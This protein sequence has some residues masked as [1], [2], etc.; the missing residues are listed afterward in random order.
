MQALRDR[1]R[2]GGYA[3]PAGGLFEIIATGSVDLIQKIDEAF[4]LLG[5]LNQH[6][7]RPVAEQNAGAAVRVIDDP[8]HRV[9]ADH[10]HFLVRCRPSRSAPPWS[11]H[12]RS[13]STPR[14]DR[15][16][17][18]PF[19]PRRSCTRHA[20]DGNI[21]SGVTVHTIIASTSEASMPRLRQR[22][23]RGLHG[24]VGSGHV[25]RRDVPLR[26]ADPLDN[27]FVGRFDHLFEVGVRQHAGR[28]VNAERRNFCS[29]Q[30]SS[31]SSVR[32]PAASCEHRLTFRTP[33]RLLSSRSAG[34]NHSAYRARHPAHATFGEENASRRAAGIRISGTSSRRNA[35]GD[36]RAHFPT[37]SPAH[38][39]SRD[40]SRVPALR[41][42]QRAGEAR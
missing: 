32:K 17:S 21:M 6:G 41:Q 35:S 3:A 37:A 34:G 12:R 38:S 1:F 30:T 4:A 5:R 27:P 18:A 7:A 11:I 40:S 10:Q 2:T 28:Y 29:G 8:R 9:G 16:P 20:V 23:P 14:P 33:L 15:I 13:R 24:H 22:D 36:L 42:R 39:R 26:N 31:P 19:A 25:R